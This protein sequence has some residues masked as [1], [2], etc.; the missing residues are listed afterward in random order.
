MSRE[1]PTPDAI[2]LSVNGEPRRVPAGCTVARLV[3]ESG[4]GG[5][6]VAVA[7][8]REVVPRSRFAERALG[9]GDRVEI[10]EAVGG[11]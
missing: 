3:E 2:E 7:V 6:K 11:G 10:L 4:L 1:T 8:N 5:R 9:A